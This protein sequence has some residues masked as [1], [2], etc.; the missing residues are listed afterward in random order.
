[1]KQSNFSKDELQAVRP[2][3]L[4]KANSSQVFL[5]DFAKTLSNPFYISKI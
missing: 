5:K 1:M 3:T 2:A 4:Q